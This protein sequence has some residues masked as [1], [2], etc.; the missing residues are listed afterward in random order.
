MLS[1]GFHE[2]S[3]AEWANKK[4]KGEG[5]GGDVLTTSYIPNLNAHHTLH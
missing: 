1:T 3:A 5:G 4:K 2:K